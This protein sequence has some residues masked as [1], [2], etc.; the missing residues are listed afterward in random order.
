MPSAVRNPKTIPGTRAGTHF[1]ATSASSVSNAAGTRKRT[2]KERG[3]IQTRSRPTGMP[4]GPQAMLP[5]TRRRT[6]STSS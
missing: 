2:R 3:A 5:K 1:G 6:S 4:R